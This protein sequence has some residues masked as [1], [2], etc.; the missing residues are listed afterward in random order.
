[1]RKKKNLWIDIVML[2]ICF[3]FFYPFLFIIMTAFKTQRDVALNPYWFTAAPTLANFEKV[4]ADAP[5]ARLFFNNLIIT[6]A[7]VIGVTLFASMAAYTVTYCRTK[8][9]RF[10]FFYILLGFYIPFQATLLPLYSLYQSLHLMD[11]LIGLILLN[12]S[13]LSMTFFMV[14]GYMKS[15][16]R[17]LRD[18]CK[19]D[20][21]SVSRAF[22][23]VIFPLCRPVL[24]TSTIFSVFGTWNNY[25]A[26]SLFL[27]SR[28]K[29][30]L[31]LEVA[32]AAQRRTTD[33]GRMFAVVLI[34]LIPVT[35][36]FMIVQRYLVTGVTAGSV[37]G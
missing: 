27:T 30:T 37:K 10:S 23:S 2:P 8:L 31:I 12:I 26:P 20:G 33:W 25:L 17:E 32:R 5:I 22:F 34:S 15:L 1:M 28:N 4:F 19:I 6:A 3:I 24:I 36:F 35:I 13:G 14:S 29:G 11:T 18:A 16:P 21:C 7:S 9:S